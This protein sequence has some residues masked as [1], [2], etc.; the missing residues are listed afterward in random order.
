M[1]C[2]V[3]QKHNTIKLVGSSDEITYWVS[4]GTLNVRKFQI[5]TFNIF[6]YKVIITPSMEEAMSLGLPR[7]REQNPSNR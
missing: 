1:K 3:D 6:M 5:V 4:S 2:C 7:L